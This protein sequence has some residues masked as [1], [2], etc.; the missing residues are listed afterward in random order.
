ML[1]VE[2]DDV[3][4]DAI[5]PLFMQ[6]LRAVL[7]ERNDIAPTDMHVTLTQLSLGQGCNTVESSCLMKIAANLHVDG[8]LFGKLTHEGGEPVAILRRYDT[9]S[10]SIDASALITFGPQ[11]SNP[12]VM[13]A[14]VDKLVTALLGENT[15]A[16]PVAPTIA[17]P[18]AKEPDLVTV[19]PPAADTGSGISTRTVA[20]FSLLGGAAI[21][22]GLTVLSFV[23]I[24]RAEHND[25][26]E[27]YRVAVGQNN[28]GAKDVCDEAS[29][30]K[31]YGLTDSSFRDVRRACSTGQT[32]EILQYVF[33]GSA[34]VTGGLATFLLLGSDGEQP[35]KSVSLRPNFG[36]SSASLTA[37]L[38]F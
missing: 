5:A 20:G 16:P 4:D 18:K 10:A 22:L 2:N 26:F 15:P 38:Q 6:E 9:R 3:Y 24:D 37:T 1:Q 21:S 30:G 8:I 7:K 32:F 12:P 29:G 33:L 14:E 17:T 23:Q 11:V 28:T 19:A 13:H 36:R 35:T 25:N 34:V 27:S 31:R